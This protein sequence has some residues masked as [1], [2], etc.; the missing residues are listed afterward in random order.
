MKESCGWEEKSQINFNFYNSEKD[1]VS[2]ITLGE[3]LEFLSNQFGKM[4]ISG[5]HYIP[6][7]SDQNQ[8]GSNSLKGWETACRLVSG[9]KTGDNDISL[10]ILINDL[11]FSV[12]E[13]QQLLTS[14]PQPYQRTMV[15]LGLGKGDLTFDS[16]RKTNYTEKRLANRLPKQI[17]KGVKKLDEV[18]SREMFRNYCITAIVAYLE[19]I[20]EQGAKIS[21]W[22]LPKCSQQNVIEAIRIFKNRRSDLKSFVFFET[23]NC[24]N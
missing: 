15:D 19:N 13:R 1:A 14:T 11:P 12:A 7:L 17:R 4:V 22:V 3:L 18:Y 5:G 23:A 9:L 16:I 10:S 24:I 8:V 6:N 2:N 20:R 21:V